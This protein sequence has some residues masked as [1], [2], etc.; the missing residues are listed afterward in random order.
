MWVAVGTGDGLLLFPALA[1]SALAHMAWPRA[2]Y[3]VS[4]ATADHALSGVDMRS[5]HGAQEGLVGLR[6]LQSSVLGLLGFSGES[7]TLAH[8]RGLVPR[9]AVPIVEMPSLGQA[10]ASP[11]SHTGEGQQFNQHRSGKHRTLA[12]NRP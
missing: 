5:S 3:Q 12:T 4:G 10:L 6:T 8:V 1:P 9:D 2:R 11:V 7:Y